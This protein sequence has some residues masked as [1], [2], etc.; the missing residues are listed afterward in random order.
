MK[1]NPPQATATPKPTSPTAPEMRLYSATGRRL[2]LNADERRRFR[3]AAL[4]CSGSRVLLCL[5]LLHTGCRISEA[6]ALR[7][8][9][10]QV[11]E[12]VI[13][14]ETLK[15]RRAGIVREIPVPR[16][17]FRWLGNEDRP[18]GQSRATAWRAVKSVLA[19][20]GIHGAHA[21]PKGL[22][23]G[24]GVHAVCRGVPLNMLAKWMGHA[25]IATTAIYANA[26]GPEER[27]IAAR[28]WSD[29]GTA[30]SGDSQ[31]AVA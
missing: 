1:E 15:R 26:L 21:S 4:A 22:R 19:A 6:L 8:E 24:Y 31:K 30:D 9:S 27:A 28:M 10:F 18:L 12:G 16:E 20:A 25:S 14:V 7:Q 11:T 17:V 13:A 5:V 29:C 3:E 23:H 2:Y